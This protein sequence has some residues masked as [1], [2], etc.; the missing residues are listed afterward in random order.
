MSGGGRKLMDEHGKIFGLVNIVD[1]VV[2]IIL[3]AAVGVV[4]VLP[5]LS[6][7]ETQEVVIELQKEEAPQYLK[8][9]IAAGPVPENGNIIS[10][11]NYSFKSTEDGMNRLTLRIRAQATFKDGYTYFN[12]DRIFIGQEITIDLTDAVIEVTVTDIRSYSGGNGD[13]AKPDPTSSTTAE[14]NEAT[15]SLTTNV[16]QIRPNFRRLHRK[17]DQTFEAG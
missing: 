11:E 3:V 12:H 13:E 8:N 7:G 4:G 14:T 2:I 6:S 5:T 10:V 17:T 15:S 9:G 1:L 16:S